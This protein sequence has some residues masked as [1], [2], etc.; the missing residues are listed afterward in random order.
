MQHSGL[1]ETWHG[2][3]QD[4][5]SA[6]LSSLALLTQSLSPSLNGV[7][8]NIFPLFSFSRITFF[9]AADGYRFPPRIAA[10]AYALCCAPAAARAAAH[11]CRRAFCVRGLLRATATPPNLGYTHTMPHLHARV[12]ST[13]TCRMPSPGSRLP[14]CIT[15]VRS[16]PP[17]RVLRSVL[18]HATFTCHSLLRCHIVR[19]AMRFT[20]LPAAFYLQL[21]TTGLLPPFAQYRFCVLPHTFACGYYRRSCRYTLPRFMPAPHSTLLLLLPCT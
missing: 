6:F 11:V 7:L 3:I 1:I 12:Y 8:S 19:T 13:A 14:L 20:I 15:A 21:R 10:T 18:R 5:S 17:L 9:C 4:S 16:A 2:R